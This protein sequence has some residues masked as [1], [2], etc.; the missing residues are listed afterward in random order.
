MPRVAARDSAK[1]GD[2][3]LRG[4]GKPRSHPS[5][6]RHCAAALGIEGGAVPEREEFAQVA[7][8]VCESEKEVLGPALVGARILGRD[9]RERDG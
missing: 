5:T 1:Q 2:G 8:R 3:D 4:V 9:Q 6:D 7:I